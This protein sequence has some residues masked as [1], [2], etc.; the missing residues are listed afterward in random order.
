[1]IAALRDLDALTVQ[2]KRDYAI[3]CT[4][5]AANREKSRELFHDLFV[6]TV[7]DR[8]MRSLGSGWVSG[9]GLVPRDALGLTDFQ[10][11]TFQLA[12]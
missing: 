3:R 10:S 1:M 11:G 12:V 2:D 5:Y 7:D 6:S 4:H 8:P 9:K